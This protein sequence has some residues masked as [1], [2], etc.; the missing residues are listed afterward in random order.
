MPIGTT[1]ANDV[2]ST[3]TIRSIDCSECGLTFGIST[4]FEQRRRTDKRSF[5]CPNGHGQYFPGPSKVEQERDAARA[6]A[7]RES[8]RRKYAER[9]ARAAENEA[10]H[11]R[12][13]AAAYKGWATRVRKRIANGV[14]P[15]CNRSFTN[16][17]RHM[18]TQHPDYTIPEPTDG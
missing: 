5:Y 12:R 1:F 10:E 4:T 2:I 11:A 6:L 18:T 7:E 9:N 8:N 16:V 13:S 17:R 3:T 15:C 14:C